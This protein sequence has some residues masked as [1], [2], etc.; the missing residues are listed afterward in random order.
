MDPGVRRDD[1][2]ELR[3]VDLAAATEVLYTDVA[4]GLLTIAEDFAGQ[5]RAN[6][7]IHVDLACLTSTYGNVKPDPGVRRDDT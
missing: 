5:Q 2:Q 7:G 1:E 4:V 6:A 3:E